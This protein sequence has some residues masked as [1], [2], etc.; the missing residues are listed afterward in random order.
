MHV[1]PQPAQSLNGHAPTTSPPNP[2]ELGPRSFLRFD[3]N[4]T[5]THTNLNLNNPR[6]SSQRS[7]HAP[8]G[9]LDDAGVARTGSINIYAGKLFDP[10]TRALRSNQLIT[11]SPASGLIT[12]VTS[13]GSVE[14]ARVKE[15][16][17]V[18]DLRNHT[19]MPGFVDVHVHLFLHEYSET[20]WDDQVTRE[21]L[22]E[23]T[24]RATVH[25][26]RTLM[27]GYTAVRDLGTE[28]AEDA[29]L[30]LRKCLSGPKP[31]APGPRYFCANRAIVT[32]GAYGP[33]NQ[34]YPN[35]DGVEGKMGAEVAD[36]VDGCVR[37][38][39]RQVG[40]G[41][42]WI[43]VYAA[44]M[45]TVAPDVAGS[46]LGVFTDAELTAIVDTAHALGVKVAA[47]SSG[48]PRASAL[49][50]G[51]V[52]S[53]E[54]AIEWTEPSHATGHLST[55][56]LSPTVWV[57]T[58]SVFYISAGNSIA[59]T[60]AQRTFRDVLRRHPNGDFKIACGGDTGVFAHGDNALEMKLM[61]RLGAPWQHVL[62]WGTLGGWE[63][64]R[65]MRWEGQQGVERLQRVEQLGE[66]ARLV[67]D[68]EVPF[69]ALRKGFAADIIA[70]AGD[71]ANNFEHAVDKGSIVF[72]MKG[73]R[74]YKR[75]GREQA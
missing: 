6:P 18:V 56:T 13:Y 53:V 58:L 74:V 45:N 72:V 46:A 16:E 14:D 70:T 73:G 20:S 4:T 24:I 33:R 59:W 57:P 51:K 36:G 23:R 62:G 9:S 5:I 12:S 10:Y 64:I 32:T 42:D 63:C 30:A 67:G 37:A 61:V 17:T 2:P 40:A 55:Q 11:V 22:A 66:D 43:K 7:A 28:G 27:A 31:I 48:G 75:D 25:A 47:H 3:P 19:V 26:R 65:S 39:R 38:V 35:R 49:L 71:I 69:G 50:A 34:L 1:H 68:N 41:A 15:S 21:S 60:K 29:D 54:H 52:D 44:N 8:S